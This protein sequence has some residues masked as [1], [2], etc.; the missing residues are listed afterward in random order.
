MDR[1]LASG[2]PGATVQRTGSNHKIGLWRV[3]APVMGLWPEASSALAREGG[4]SRMT[5]E[6]VN[7]TGCNRAN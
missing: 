7:K 5:D 2:S 3:P 4:V 6:A 1:R